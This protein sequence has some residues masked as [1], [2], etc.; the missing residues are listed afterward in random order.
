MMTF[1]SLVS[2]PDL[3]L[4]V[5]IEIKVGK[6]IEGNTWTATGAG[7]WWSTHSEGEIVELKE[8]GVALT[9]QANVAACDAAAGWYYDHDARRIY[10]HPTGNDIPDTLDGGSYKY[11]IIGYMWWGFT[12]TQQAEYP[13]EFAPQDGDEEIYYLPYLSEQAVA[14]IFQAV[15][16]VV[17]QGMPTF[18]T[19]IRMNNDGWWYG[20]LENYIWHN[21][22]AEIKIG[23]KNDAYGD[24][25]TVFIG[26][27]RNP[28]V[29]DKEAVLQFRDDR[30]GELEDFPKEQY[31]LTTYPNLEDRA[32]GLYIPVLFGKKLGITPIQISTTLYTFK[33]AGHALQS[34]DAVYKDGGV[35]LTGGGVD[36]TA[37]LP[38]GEFTLTADPGTAVVTCDAHGA[39]CDYDTGLYSENVA[40]I[41]Y[42]ILNTIHGVVAG[43]IDKPSFDALKVAKTQKISYYV[44]SPTST[45]QFI[46]L[47]QRTV[48][49]KFVPLLAGKYGVVLY[50]NA[51]PGDV[52]VLDTEDYDSFL[53]LYDS[54]GVFRRVV[55]RYDQDP[56]TKEWL[57]VAYE[58]PTVEYRHDETGEE[59]KVDT[60]LRSKGEASALAEYLANVTTTPRK[61]VTATVSPVVLDR[62]PTEKLY[63]TRDIVGGAG[64]DISILSSEVYRI[65]EL[66]KNVHSGKTRVVAQQDSQTYSAVHAD[67]AHIDTHTDSHSDSH[68]NVAYEDEHYDAV[69]EDVAHGDTAYDDVA[70][71]DTPYVDTPHEDVL[72]IDTHTDEHED[73]ED[74]GYTDTHDDEYDD[75][76]H[77]DEAHGDDAYV[78]THTD[79][80]HDDVPHE[81]EAHDDEHYDAAYTDTH[82]DS[83]GDEHGD[84]DYD[85]S[86]F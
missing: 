47:L 34:I 4:S 43:R 27:V 35:A 75:T 8:D 38:N 82:G 20:V 23:E 31:D 62:E 46:Q 64:E 21:R 12:T 66:R 25:T 78:D 32:D 36:Y 18:M 53:L 67:E 33:I 24:Y 77:A 2:K 45:M 52:P 57:E 48:M 7:S 28:K 40:D 26:K 65:L 74:D 6:E 63:L 44:D 15:A 81:D 51:I 50:T 58:N 42:Y 69:H 86:D 1:A 83:Y 16:K 13:I 56:S 5:I 79:I 85:D 37:D 39:K 41:L 59:L 70:H 29:T 61:E 19:Q 73:H 60:A 30:V 84:Y 80:P 55:V 68:G 54:G 71:V 3:D 10:V 14:S 17:G 22:S 49:F 76:P 11:V 9:E 72:Y